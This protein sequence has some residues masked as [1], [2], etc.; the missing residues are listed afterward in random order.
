M[1]QRTASLITVILALTALLTPILFTAIAYKLSQV[2][3][4]RE[5]M[6]KFESSVKEDIGKI[7][8]HL[9]S[10]DNHILTLLQRT[11]RLRVPGPD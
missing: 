2:F 3:A 10:V 11:A 4:T 5:D 7:E 6:R 1:D 8:E 9:R